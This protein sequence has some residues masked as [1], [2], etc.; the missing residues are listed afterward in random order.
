MIRS[1]NP[2]WGNDWTTGILE[3]PPFQFCSTTT[4]T[5][6]LGG[7]SHC[8]ALVDPEAVSCS[9]NIVSFNV[10]IQNND[11]TWR[12]KDKDCGGGVELTERSWTIS[13]EAGKVGRLRAYDLNTGHWGHNNLDNVIECT[14]T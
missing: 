5:Y 10:E 11:N 13:D 2:G 1:Q 7:G 6:L 4:I 14:T 12:G 3:S 8:D 9:S